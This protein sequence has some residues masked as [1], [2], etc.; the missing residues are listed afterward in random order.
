[1]KLKSRVIVWY[2]IWF[3]R[4]FRS[5]TKAL[6]LDL[7]SPALGVG[8]DFHVLVGGFDRLVDEDGSGVLEVVPCDSLF[9]HLDDGWKLVRGDNNDF[10]SDSGGF[11]WVV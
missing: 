8:H 1:M 6:T 11:L 7:M 4:S 10:I 5:L 9:F 3:L 2:S